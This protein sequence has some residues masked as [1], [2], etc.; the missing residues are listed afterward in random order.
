MTVI[1][2]PKYTDERRYSLPRECLHDLRADIERLATGSDVE[3]RGKEQIQIKAPKKWMVGS[4]LPKH[5]VVFLIFDPQTE[6][7]AGYALSAEAAIGIA[8][9]LVKQAQALKHPPDGVSPNA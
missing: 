3:P 1:L 9:E 7:Q 6:A 4:A 8:A 5:R 2:K